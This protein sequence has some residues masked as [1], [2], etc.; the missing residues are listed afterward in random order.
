MHASTIFLAKLLGLYCLLM[1]GGMLLNR[2][3][4]LAAI[5]AMIR[6]PQMLLMSGVVALPAGLALV[7]LHTVWSG[8][9][10]AVVVTV[11]GWAV[12]IKAVSLIALPQDTMLGFYR[13]L[14]YDRWFV[15]WMA[16]VAVIGLVLA[17]AGFAG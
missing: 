10:L 14:H 1:A 7:L 6:S 3:D 2:R 4:S 13:T 16:A 5:E 8:G 15:P 11:F 12:L 9:V 17:L